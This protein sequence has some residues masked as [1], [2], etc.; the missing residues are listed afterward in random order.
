MH[1]AKEQTLIFSEFDNIRDLIFTHSDVVIYKYDHNRKTYDY[2]S[3]SI[4]NLTG[5]T[6]DE[7]N[8]FGFSKIVKKVECSYS[9]GDN[10]LDIAE[11]FYG[12][13]TIQTKTGE[14]KLIE[15]LSFHDPD[16]LGNLAVSVGI[17]RD[18][19]QLNK[20]FNNLTFEKNNLNSIIDLADVIVI[21]IDRNETL[22]KVNKKGVAISGYTEE[23]LLGN[24]WLKTIPKESQLKFKTKKLRNRKN[25]EE[26]PIEMELPLVT[27]TG[28]E[29]IIS[30]HIS[31]L[32]NEKGELVLSV[33]IGRDVTQ[34][35]RDEKVQQIISKILFYSNV[36]GSL[37]DF[38]DFIRNSIKEFMP[39]ENFYIALY[40]REND[41]ITFPYFQDEVDEEAFSVKFRHGLTEYI[42]NSGKSELIDEERDVQLVKEGKVDLVGAPSKIWLGIPLIIGEQTIGAL[43][44]QDYHDKNTYGIREKEILEVIGYSI[45]RAIERKRLE[46]ERKELIVKLENLN[47]SKDKLFSLISHDLR[48][49]FNS[50]LGFSE[51]L[52]TE[53]DTLTKEEIKEY[54]NAIYESSKNLYNMTT[55]LLQYSR[56]QVGRIIYEPE[57]LNLLDLVEHNLNLLKGNYLKKQIDVKVNIDRGLYIFAD[58]D[59]MNSVVQNLLSNSIKF[60]YRGGSIT[61]DASKKIIDDKEKIELIIKDTGVGMEQEKIEKIFSADVFSCPG[62]EKEIGTGLGLQLVIQFIEKNGGSIKIESI[63][64]EGTSFTINLSSVKP[65]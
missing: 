45:S 40:D 23:E 27:K 50:L 19:T 6:K 42:I 58:E 53:F 60:T 13:Y 24:G 34:K 57:I 32:T 2:I 31:E 46:Q 8:D 33:G 14:L 21:V 26:T 41:L 51:I 62:T 44:V 20:V 9:R 17:L 61:I 63:E 25:R 54:Q 12:N 18:I 59:M 36:G 10:K 7:I 4:K 28:E 11:D 5:Y 43:V 22:S 37:E 47:L 64:N 65:E 56:F 55:N 48:A 30:W 16:E 35:R 3:P 29:K 49:P 39:V 52:T 38:F 1:L 15:D